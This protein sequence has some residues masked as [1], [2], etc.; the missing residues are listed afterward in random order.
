M[1]C[2]RERGVP[3]AEAFD[4]AVDRKLLRAMVLGEEVSTE[5]LQKPEAFCPCQLT[6]SPPPGARNPW[7]FPFFY[8]IRSM[9]TRVD[10]DG[11]RSGSC[12]TSSNPSQRTTMLKPLHWINMHSAD[13]SILVRCPMAPHGTCRL[14]LDRVRASWAVYQ[15]NEMLSASVQCI[16]WVAL[17]CLE[18]ERPTLHTTEDV[19]RWFATSSWVS[20]VIEKLPGK[21][22]E[23][24]LEGVI[25]EL[26]PLGGVVDGHA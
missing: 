19:V 3:L 23:T 1:E 12:L 5:Q 6:D 18:E 17:Q 20:Q 11:A 16:F 4:M 2:T 9:E 10:S 15:R 14:D 21:D 26:P 24:A 7:G 13:A 22:F 8:E 25:E